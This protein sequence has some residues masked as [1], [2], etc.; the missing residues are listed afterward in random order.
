M[1][2]AGIV[3]FS[4]TCYGTLLYF[5]ATRRAGLE[6][7]PADASN[8]YM[9]IAWDYD[10][11]IDFAEWVSGIKNRRKEISK[12]LR[13]HVLESAVGTGRNLAFYPMEKIE[14]ITLLDKSTEMLACTK[15]K[16][17]DE[18]PEYS[19]KINYKNQSA[20]CPITPITP[21]GYDT[22]FQTM[23]LCST[24]EPVALLR[25]LEQAAK[26]DGQI[27]LLE[28]GKSYYEWMNRVLDNTAP[29]HADKWGCWWNK[30]IGKIVEE[31]GLEVVNIKRYNFGTTWWVELKPRKGIRKKAEAMVE[32]EPLLQVPVVPQ[33]PWW[34]LWR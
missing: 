18:W 9:D 1:I 23:G 17:K 27:L 24:P 10:K 14:T 20:L 34:Y 19:R 12:L 7:I 25:N 13:G 33:R 30:D 3:V 15:K 16:Y 4:A 28:H 26:E 6:N 32:A 22:V 2:G 5:S 29:D 21:E 11:N 8:R 31:S